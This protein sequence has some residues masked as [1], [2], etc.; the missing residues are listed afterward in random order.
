M[1]NQL[2][3]AKATVLSL[4][5]SFDAE[6][7][8]GQEAKTFS[9]LLKHMPIALWQVDST[10]PADAFEKLKADGVVDIEAY[11]LQNPELIE[12]ACDTVM[13]TRA[14][15]AAL[16]L[17]GE[18]DDAFYPRSVRH[19]FEATPQAAVRVMVAHFHGRRTHVEELRINTADGRVVDVLFLVTFPRPPERL[20][21]T[22]IM[23]LEITD[24]LATEAHLRQ[25]Q[26]DLAHASRVS[27]L[28]ELATSIAHE[29]RQPLG[30]IMLNGTTSLRWLERPEPNLPKA[31]QLIERMVEAAT[32]ATEIIDR[33]QGMASKRVPIRTRIKLNEIVDVALRFVHHES[34]ERRVAIRA[35]LDPDIHDIDGDRIQ[36]QQV[37]VNLL[38]NAMHAIDYRTSVGPRQVAVSTRMDAADRVTLVVADTGP[39]IAEEHLDS[40]FD[41]FFSTKPEGMGMGLT[42]CSSIMRSHNGNISAANREGGG[43]IFTCNM[44]VAG[45]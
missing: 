43:A 36:L 28:G 21:V 11:L 1:S 14:N 40:L 34:I 44:P 17:I 18:T 29:V 20:D 26:A 10:S 15:D 24:R 39:G 8:S 3:E 41:G 38:V 23:M 32:Q 13:V 16:A 45:G 33:I 4:D 9:R 6:E 37:I 19:I 22:F 30:A 7:V 42:I 31:R 25:L 2:S 12:F 35:D 27:T 5:E